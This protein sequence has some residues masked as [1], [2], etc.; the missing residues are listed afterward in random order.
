MSSFIAADW[1]IRT[2]RA[3]ETNWANNAGIANMAVS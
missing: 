1:L 3:V 2:N